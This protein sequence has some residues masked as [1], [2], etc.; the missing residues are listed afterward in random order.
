MIASPLPLQCGG[1]EAVCAAMTAHPA[2]AMVQLAALLCLIPLALENHMMQ[3]GGCG[4]VGMGVGA[5]GGEEGKAGWEG[6]CASNQAA[7]G[8][9]VQQFPCLAAVYDIG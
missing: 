5:A 6:G 4:R 3:V 2:S 8:A 7:R 9:W 1:I